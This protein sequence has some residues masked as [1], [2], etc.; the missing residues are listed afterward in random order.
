MEADSYDS[1]QRLI[2]PHAT[3]PMFLDFRS[4]KAFILVV[5]TVAV[6]TDTFFYALIIP[7]LP[8]LLEDRAGVL[9]QQAQQWISILLSAYALANLI[10]SPIAGFISDRNRSRKPALLGG[11]VAMAASTTLF[12]FSRTPALLLIARALQGASAA[13][14]RVSGLALISDT[15]GAGQSGAAMGWQSVG[16][17]LGTFTGPSISGFLYDNFGHFAVFIAA[18]SVLGIDIVLRLVMIE[19]K[20]AVRWDDEENM[21]EDNETTTLIPQAQE[22]RLENG[23]IQPSHIILSSESTGDP[24]ATGSTFLGAS[25]PIIALLKDRRLLAALW[26]TFSCAIIMTALEG[27]LPLYT[28][29]LFSWTPTQTGLLIV[30]LSVSIVIDPLLGS[31]ADKYGSRWFSVLGF[32][33]VTTVCSLATTIVHNCSNDKISIYVLLIF[34]G[35]AIGA[36]DT[37]NMVEI[38]SLV[39]SAEEKRTLGPFRADQVMGQAYGALSVSYQLGSLVGPVWGGAVMTSQGWVVMCFSFAILAGVSAIVMLLFAGE[40]K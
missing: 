14:I 28:M 37:P 25:L 6:F 7:I 23:L 15:F 38:S 1:S 31:L 13:V 9:P 19:R 22:L 40:R 24:D 36:I 8:D 21:S 12:T 17:F 32:A 16:M 5:V 33:A 18:Y 20:E 11:L 3:K 27:V 26:A 30:A 2:N 35:F 34:L 39:N 4:S 29:Q 10:T